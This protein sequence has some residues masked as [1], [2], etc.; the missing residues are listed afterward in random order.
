MINLKKY[1]PFLIAVLVIV[2]LLVLYTGYDKESKTIYPEKIIGVISFENPAH[3]L[4]ELNKIAALA[5]I[6]LISLAF[7][8][9]PLSRI[10]PKTFGK[11][12]GWRTALGLMG[13]GFALAHVAYSTI[14]IF[15]LN[16]DAMVFS[17]PKW[18]ALVAAIVSILIFSLMGITSLKRVIKR[19]SHKN[20]KRLQRTGYIALALAIIHFVVIETKPGIGFDVRPYG[21]LFLIIAVIALALKVVSLFLKK[22]KKM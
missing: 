9:G 11:F 10:W 22:S 16:L 21:Y 5:A 4:S 12:A 2:S 13:L 18:P 20:W 1:F 3:S 8:I 7:V 6:G 17:N 19:M 15:E 14:V